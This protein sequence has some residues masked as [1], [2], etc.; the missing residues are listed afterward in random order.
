MWIDSNAYVG[1][2]PFRQVTNN[3]C[4]SAVER[5]EKF[6]VDISLVTNMNGV[7]Y[8]N[9]QAANQELHAEIRS[10]GRWK[11]R[12]LPFAVINPIY[13]GWRRDME[14]SLSKLGMKGIRLFPK[15]HRYELT[16]PH[17]VELVKR[18]RDRGVPVGLTLRMVDSRPSSWLDIT[19]EWTLKDILPIIKA[20]PDGQFMILN[21][22]N[23]TAM[24][25][26][27]LSLIKR[28]NVFMDTS[29]RNIVDLGGLMSTFGKDKFGFG[30]HSPILDYRTGALRIAALR[31][32][33]AS[34]AIR[35]D[36][37][38]GN[39]MRFMRL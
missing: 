21:I 8:K 26:E 23:S 31:E 13:S 5:M 10:N 11:E 14:E 35:Q 38:S 33:E 37:M 16:N 17:C 39:I 29:G 19:D 34:P 22:A 36:L 24:E 27:G 28:A 20:V 1:H 32:E 18:A 2:W 12:L 9:T 15:Y 25:Q 30:S 6:G 4:K 3:S 7:F